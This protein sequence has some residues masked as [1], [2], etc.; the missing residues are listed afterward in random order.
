V[1]LLEIR[2]KIVSELCKNDFKNE[3]IKF[4]N[5]LFI[6]S[7]NDY[8]GLSMPYEF[9]L[10]VFEKIDTLQ[11]I[12]MKLTPIY[13]SS[14]E[15]DILNVT[16]SSNYVILECD[17]FYGYQITVKCIEKETSKSK[18]ISVWSFFIDEDCKITLSKLFLSKVLK[19]N[20]KKLKA[21]IDC[22]ND[23]NTLINI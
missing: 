9:K 20:S 14:L 13:R 17:N 10:E 18:G 12:K 6:I 2:K 23:L 5:D 15:F 3:I 1:D 21:I 11:I 8:V 7:N 4:D 19:L 22:E 16:D